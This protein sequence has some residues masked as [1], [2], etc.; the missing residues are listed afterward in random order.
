MDERFKAYKRKGNSYMRPYVKGEDLSRVS[1]SEQ[2]NPEA[3]MGMIA[4]NPD[5][6]DDQWYVAREYFEKNLEPAKGPFLTDFS[7]NDYAD[8]ANRTR[9]YPE[10]H[11]IIYPALK[12][13][14][15]AGEVSE[16]V[17]KVLRDEQ[18][19]FSA[20]KRQELLK[21]LGDV[22]WYIN[23]MAED[24][25]SSLEN[26]AKMNNEKLLDRLDRNRLQGSG[27]NR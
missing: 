10:K 21:E 1:V 13:T 5:N 3:D 17:G 23:A 16:K 9:I 6:P 12:L 2:D 20:D 24:L 15:E 18:G 11:R 25:G 7:F 19:H 27:D 4:I 8:S 14:G 22:L 26:V